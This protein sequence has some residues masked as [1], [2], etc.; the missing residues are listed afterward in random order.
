MEQDPNSLGLLSTPWHSMRCL[1][2]ICSQ[3]G[4]KHSSRSCLRLAGCCQIEYSYGQVLLLICRDCVAELCSRCV[5]QMD[6]LTVLH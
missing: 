6:Q 3:Q 2:Q 1:V 4:C 5:S